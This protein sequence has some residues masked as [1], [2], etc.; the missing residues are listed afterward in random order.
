MKKRLQDRGNASL[1]SALTLQQL[2]LM[3][4]LFAA[5]A[6]TLQAAQPN[7]WTSRGAVNTSLTRNDSAALKE[8]QLKKMT[9]EAVREMNA[10]LPGGAGSF[11]SNM[12]VGWSNDY[13]ANGPST[14]DVYLMKVGQL[15]YIASQVYAPLITQGYMAAKPSWLLANTG[16]DTNLAT[17]GQLKQ[18]FAFEIAAPQTPTQ[19]KVVVGSTSATL[20]WSDPV[21]SI[22]NFA[23]QYSSDGGANWSSAVTVSGTATSSTVT[24]L[25]LGTNYLF[26]VYASNPAGSSATTNDA[27]PIITLATPSG[28]I[29][30][31]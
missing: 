9:F 18:V 6:V 31:P 25:T 7:W 19:F 26:R 14:N 24:G 16:F 20:S 12:A 4:G 21:I 13:V 29:L 3:A 28:A 5:L 27:S 30:V 10:H 11:L 17:L 2:G 22:Q 15:K 1:L 8:G 23:Y